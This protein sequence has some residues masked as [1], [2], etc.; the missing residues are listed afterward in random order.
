MS[1]NN[2]HNCRPPD[3][4]STNVSIYSI[5]CTRCILSRGLVKRVVGQ[6]TYKEKKETVILT[7][8]HSFWLLIQF[9]PAHSMSG[10]VFLNGALYNIFYNKNNVGWFQQWPVPDQ[11]RL[12]LRT[13]IRQTSYSQ[14]CR[15]CFFTSEFLQAFRVG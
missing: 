14:T 5:K 11:H 10:E 3:S 8:S 13:V 15:L 12:G 9:A 2:I 7:G 6:G 4:Q 1:Q